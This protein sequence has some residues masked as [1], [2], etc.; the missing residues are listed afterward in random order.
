MPD[1]CATAWE[2]AV[3]IFGGIGLAGAPKNI[4]VPAFNIRSPMGFLM[5]KRPRPP[6]R[7]DGPLQSTALAHASE[8]GVLLER[9]C[10]TF[11]PIGLGRQPNVTPITG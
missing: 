7:A 5:P 2:M 6:A 10:L 4:R 1:T 3:A 8:W 9:M 11:D